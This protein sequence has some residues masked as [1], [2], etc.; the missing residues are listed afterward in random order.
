VGRET[1]FGLLVGV[2][3]IVLFG[4]ILSGRAGSSVSEHAAM[5]T[6]EVQRHHTA[7][8]TLNQTVDPFVQDAASDVKGNDLAAKE[9]VEEPLPA[10]K[11]AVVVKTPDTGADTC[12][13][14]GIGPVTIET[15]AGV[16]D[17]LLAK[18]DLSIA[19]WPTDGTIVTPSPDTTKTIYTV[20]AGDTL[21]SVARQYYGK[22]A[23]RLWKQIYEANKATVKDPNRLSAGLKLVIPPPPAPADSAKP[24]AP[25]KDP[26]RDLG[27]DS[28][29][30]AGSGASV[31]AS[32]GTPKDK[33]A[34]REALKSMTV[35]ADVPARLAAKDASGAAVRDVTADDLG[36]MFGNQSDLA[37]QP[38]RPANTYTV[39]AGDTF[40]KI[41][42]K[43]YGDG[44]KYGRLLYLKNQHLVSDAT[45]LKIGQR[46]VLLDG[47]SAASS[48]SA[49][50]SR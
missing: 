23:P 40:H 49:V 24:A 48:D 11:G 44:N 30:A 31:P 41:A 4:V 13:T 17:G 43:L 8:Q 27:R 20:R 47:V 2:V 37:D 32:P 28:A 34:L 45:K 42:E 1:K 22:D 14:V 21:T 15:P 36:H 18:A 12:G 25:T 10:P 5:P 7:V 6:G 26:S 35:P 33:A 39:Q 46:I 16:P 19:R 38:S 50:A 9:P 3:F 29:L